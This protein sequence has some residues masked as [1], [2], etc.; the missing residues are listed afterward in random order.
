MLEI[1]RVATRE[2]IVGADEYLERW[3]WSDDIE[4]DGEPDV[5]AAAVIA[6]LSAA[7]MPPGRTGS[8]T[9]EAP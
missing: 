1:A 4:R 3:Q 8:A 6:E 7:W 5:V 2:N 9:E